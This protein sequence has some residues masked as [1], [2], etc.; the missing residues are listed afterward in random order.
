MVGQKEKVVRDKRIPTGVS[1]LDTLIQG[2][3]ENRSTNLLIGSSGTGKSIFAIQFLK[4]GMDQGEKCLYVT[5]EE[6]KEEVYANMLEF[7]WDLEEY[8]KKGLFLF[9][10]YSPEKIRVMLE[11]G[12]GAIES[13][14]VKNKITRI[15]IDSI[16][17][18]ELLFDKQL[19]KRE[20]ALSLFK[21]ISAWGCT[22]VLTYEG[23]P[24]KELDH[25]ALE[26]Q[27]DSIIL[28][29]YLRSRSKRERYVEIL[30]MRG[31]KHAENVYR[32][33]IED[34][35]IEVD[36]KPYEGKSLKRLY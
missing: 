7:G 11:E 10:E 18:F 17:S 27:S 36:K 31:T 32:F 33:S 3:F 15:V 29:Y 14:V 4:Q 16:T 28:L 24:L 1:G 34:K 19:E 30:K 12:G 8:E 35:G 22:T 2:G 20:A 23:D 26:F 6:R 25:K 21:M 5:F 13:L 9:L